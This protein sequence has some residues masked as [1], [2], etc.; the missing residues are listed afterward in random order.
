MPAPANLVD[1]A[2]INYGLTREFIANFNQDVNQ[3]MEL[4]GIVT[5][6]T[7]GAGYGLV[8][9]KV[10]GE[11]NNAK[12]ANGSSGT[13]YVE[14]DL[15]SLSKYTMTEVPVGKVKLRPYR[16]VTSAQ[17]I[18]EHGHIPAVVRTD[19]KMLGDVRDDIIKQFFTFLGNGT[20]TA[21]GKTLQ[22]AFAYAEAKLQDTLE[23]NHDN[24]MTGRIVHFV[25]R[26]DVADYLAN[27]QV[28][29][30]TAF[31]MTYLQDFLGIQNVFVTNK[32]PAK[33][34]Y[35]TP[36]ENLHMYA[37]EF[38]ELSS[39]GLTYEVSDGGLLGVYHQPLHDHVSVET[40]IL[41]G[42]TLFAEVTDYIVKGTI[43]PGA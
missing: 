39:A 33:T 22:A 21:T 7:V 28:S 15:V 13:A 32:V 23:A 20:G 24:G 34:I 14:G 30:Q 41:T 9:H 43:A 1:S 6:E 4:L 19:N 2:A 35:A 26:T 31:G 18:V 3:L 5:P 40:D 29:T 27:A 16:K 36:S 10:T 17:A 42:A 38:A 12:D 37:P 8:Q 25:N 11:L